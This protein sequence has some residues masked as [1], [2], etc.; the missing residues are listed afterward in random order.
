MNAAYQ[1]IALQVA[2]FYATTTS[3]NF[4]DGSQVL[5]LGFDSRCQ[6]ERETHRR[7]T[8]A[9]V[10][11]ETRNVRLVLLADRGGIARR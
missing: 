9:Y 4:A 8:T 1:N 6:K 7:G 5:F 11:N 10:Y 2:G 3:T